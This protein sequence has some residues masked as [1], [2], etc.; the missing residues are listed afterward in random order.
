MASL[1]L[2][3]WMLRKDLVSQGDLSGKFVQD[4][5]Q[6]RKYKEEKIIKCAD[7]TYDIFASVEA[8]TLKKNGLEAYLIEVKD[9]LKSLGIKNTEKITP[10]LF[11]DLEKLIFKADLLEVEELIRYAKLNNFSYFT[12]FDNTLERL[13]RKNP[14]LQEKLEIALAK[15]FHRVP[16]SR[17]FDTPPL[18]DIIAFVS[19]RN[20]LHSKESYIT[21]HSNG[22]LPSGFMAIPINSYP[23]LKSWRQLWG[24]PQLV[25]FSD[26]KNIV[27]LLNVKGK[28]DFTNRRAKVKKSLNKNSPDFDLLKVR[29]NPGNK[30]SGGYEEFT[31]WREFTDSVDAAQLQ[32]R[33]NG[34]NHYTLLVKEGDISKITDELSKL[35]YS[36]PTELR[37]IIGS[38]A[39]SFLTKLKSIAFIELMLFD[40][41]TKP[42]KDL[43]KL[44]NYVP[45][46]AYENEKKWHEL[47]KKNIIFRLFPA[48]LD[49]NVKL[50]KTVG[51]TEVKNIL[52]NKSENLLPVESWFSSSM[53]LLKQKKS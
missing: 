30:M 36:S 35:N 40:K 48:K 32:N 16:N 18:D 42:I 47:R 53:R 39:Y 41:T 43:N 27:R 52:K 22:Q 17:F 9:N 49:R 6:R 29:S 13:I 15:E 1:I 5:L 31:T 19:A 21:A 44:A 12:Q 45:E 8:R 7:Y 24:E 4:Y 25:N 34:I 26:A 37:K 20:E 11:D 38:N 51:W 46:Y 50:G 14:P 33:K 3:V 28:T 23:E 2:E 10:E